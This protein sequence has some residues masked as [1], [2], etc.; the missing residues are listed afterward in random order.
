[1]KI[2]T[3]IFKTF[4]LSLC[5][6]ANTHFAFAQT[7]SILPPAKTTFLD[8]N[9]KPLT[10]GTVDFY[11]PGTTT[12][13]TTWQNSA[14]T[15]ANTNPVKLDAA[16]RA[17]ILGD[18]S[19]RQVVKDRAGNIIWDQVTASPASGSGG[20]GTG[21]NNAVG[22]I[23][24]YAGA[25]PP[26]NY[27]FAYGQAISR[28]T[29]AA[30]F[31]A[32]TIALNATCV[33]GSPTLNS[34]SDTSQIGVGAAVESTCLPINTTVISK[35][36]STV[37]L[38][39]NAIVS[40]SV[41]TTFFPFGNGDGL[42][43]LNVPDM[44]GKTVVGRCNMGGA[45]CSNLTSTYYGADPNGNGVNGGAQSSTIVVGN[46][47]PYTPIGTIAVT[48]GAITNTPN[49]T[50]FSAAASGGS[51]QS[52]TNAAGTVDFVV[53]ASQAA[54]TATFTG[55]AQGGTSTA[56]ANVQPS[57]TLN[58]IVKVLPDSGGGGG[59]G[60][61]SSV[62]AGDTTLNI[63]PNT[64]NVI[65]SI[66]LA[67]PN[68]W[69]G[70]QSFPNGSIPNAT[71]LNS[72]ISVNST[73]CTLGASC[74]IPAGG[75]VTSVSV[76]A[77]NGLS[78]SVTN[79]TT[80]PTISLSTTVTGMLKGNGAAISAAT[81]GTDYQAP[82]S[83][84]TTGTSGAA[85]F[86]G[87]IL[88]I[89]QYTGG[90]G[91]GTAFKQNFIAGSDFTPGSTTTLTLTTTPSAG[92]AVLVSFD[93]VEQTGGTGTAGD[94]WTLATNV[95][96]FSSAITA[97]HVVQV[98][99]LS[100]TGGGGTGTVTN[101]SIV[102]AN[103]F[104]GSVATSST[105]PALTLTTSVTG[106]LKG[107]GTAISA[108]T[109]GTDYQ[110]PISL[111]TTGTSGAATFSGGV[112]NIPQYTG[113]GTPGGINTYVQ[114][115]NSGAF[116]GSNLFTFDGTG[117]NAA[118]GTSVAK[119][120]S[121]TTLGA[122][123][124]ITASGLQ[125]TPTGSIGSSLCLDTS[126][127]VIKNASANCFGT[128]GSSINPF[129]DAVATCGVDNA[130]GTT[131]TAS[132]NTTAIQNCISTYTSVAFRKGLYLV[133][134]SA[135]AGLGIIINTNNVAITGIG[136]AAHN[137][138]VGE[139]NS[140]TFYCNNSTG[141]IFTRGTSSETIWISGMVLD[142][143][144]YT[145]G[146]GFPAI[147]AIGSVTSGA[148]IGYTGNLIDILGTYKDIMVQ[149]QFNGIVFPPSSYGNIEGIVAQNNFGDGILFQ[150]H[151]TL[152]SFQ[153]NL[154]NVLSQANNGYGF[155][156]VNATTQYGTVGQWMGTGT[157]ANGA[158]GYYFQAS[159]GGSSSVNDVRLSNINSSGDNN[160]CINFNTNGEHN[161]LIGGLL[162]G[163]GTGSGAGHAPVGRNGSVSASL[164][165]HGVVMTGNNTEVL[166]SGVAIR[167]PAQ[168]NIYATSGTGR[169]II[170]GTTLSLP[171][172]IAGGNQAIVVAGTTTYGAINGNVVI[173]I[174][175]VAALLANSGASFLTATGN[176]F[177]G[178]GCGGAAFVK[179]GNIGTGC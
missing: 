176:V 132:A 167:A 30:Y 7:A 82:I 112:L 41:A 77:A 28:T 22:V 11:I 122:T 100:A 145:T 4:F 144:T 149:N 38:N 169:L 36:S 163:C 74:V 119:S 59:G 99:G 9:G 64:G 173:D 159:G 158:G 87:N 69:T 178:G 84:T 73:T 88:N 32:T 56:F 103:G 71:L 63:A 24:A 152:G 76:A 114:Y 146:G 127:N 81:A 150:S 48:N 110:A 116:G 50:H 51:F 102:S 143:G 141:N 126:N 123:G 60:A 147:A 124:H 89:P 131:L 148:G 172:Q 135:N 12:R 129:V 62:S 33:S 8:N 165:G 37:T 65:A 170:T 79:P 171:N 117:I 175:T 164:A 85:T 34:I 52:L 113:G 177:G 90:G 125:T 44:R 93:G 57:L 86:S 39:N 92:T 142:R 42:T 78:G 106:L 67:N 35:T 46:L 140:T 174:V 91:S 61:V 70:A 3:A 121:V 96:T 115:N 72:S 160:S 156:V 107:N 154:V 26:T 13:K 138:Q 29:Y 66:N 15:I 168:S 108:A 75:T 111:T 18:G 139:D 40:T 137:G 58:Y 19:Y 151:A 10:S 133:D 27:L 20:G 1:M 47:P 162:E 54:S 55:T 179:S 136:S 97:T 105:T 68:T 14:E 128:G 53:I 25:T 130:H 101:F 80:A 153:Q 120:A 155:H 45:S 94:T 157:F 21:D 104:S 31:T 134:C 5:V 118:L 95:I 16:G 161:Q 166:I 83:L 17:I 98:V 49:L 43:T 109:S 23:V 6:V 2:A